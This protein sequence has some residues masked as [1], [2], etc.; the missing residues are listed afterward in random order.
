MVAKRET[1][2]RRMERTRK[3]L[4]KAA[5]DGDSVAISKLRKVKKSAKKRAA[6]SYERARGKKAL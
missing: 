2:R 1:C 6:N 5:K 3:K 4:R